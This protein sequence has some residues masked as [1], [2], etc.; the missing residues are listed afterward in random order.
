M[1]TPFTLFALSCLTCL[2]ALAAGQ[3]GQ[4]LALIA[5]LATI[6]SALLIFL[7]GKPSRSRQ[8]QKPPQIPWVVIDGSNVLFWSP[9]G[10][11]LATVV[12]VLRRV[13]AAG[14]CP[15]VWFDANVGYRVGDRWLGPIE[16]AKAL[17]IPCKQVFVAEK[18]HPAD[19]FLLKMAIQRGARVIT[20][21]RYRDWVAQFPDIKKPGFLIQ[22]RFG[23]K[24][25]EL[26]PAMA[27]AIAA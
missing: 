12:Q 5:G 20:N 8:S 11:A 3:G 4:D 19:P 24:G 6:A 25:V 1:R 21:D 26:L 14:L 7:P 18:G 15:V 10:A 27:Q 9:T 13:E 16:L 23:A 22:G 2:A 17:N